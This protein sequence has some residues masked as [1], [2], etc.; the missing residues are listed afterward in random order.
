MDDVG[1]RLAPGERELVDFQPLAARVQ[2]EAL[3][4][5]P[6]VV[7]EIGEA[8]R[9]LD[10]GQRARAFE[11]LGHARERLAADIGTPLLDD[12]SHQL[13]LAEDALK[14]GRRQDAASIL[15]PLGRSLE[16]VGL[17][18]PLVPVR[19]DLRAAAASA[20][21]GDWERARRFV[22]RAA[23]RLD[24]L[25]GVAPGPEVPAL[26][27]EARRLEKAIEERRSPRG[28]DLWWLAGRTRLGA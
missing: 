8:H 3:F 7:R 16:Q 28:A 4:L 20:E 25:Q 1:V 18:A 10:G 15:G 11:L 17:R 23:A 22:A 12:A 5:D 19:F 14:K 26:L 6:D 13:A 2:A 9:E 24:A 27:Q 21:L